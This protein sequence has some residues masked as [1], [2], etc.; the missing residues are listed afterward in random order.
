[1]NRTIALFNQAGGVGKSTLTMNLGFH[2][3]QRGRKVLLVDMDPQGSLTLFMGLGASEL[4]KTV[5]NAVVE[6]EPIP[7][8][9]DIHGMDLAPSNIDLSGAEL[10]LVVADLRDYRLRNVLDPI[11]DQYDDILIDCPPSLG[12]LSYISLVAATHVLIP[13]ETHNKAL[14]GTELLFQTLARVQKGA[15]RSLRVAGIIPT[16]Y[17]SRTAQGNRSLKSIQQLGD[18]ISVFATIPNAIAFA[19]ASEKCLPLALYSSSHPALDALEAIAERLD[20]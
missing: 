16:M 20:T 17:D 1:M 15:N 3:S 5:Y 8:H 10:A 18:R 4:D 19:D 9:T 13:I 12:I 6:D 7:I 14:R 2:L 11:R